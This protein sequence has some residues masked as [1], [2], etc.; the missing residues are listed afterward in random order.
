M[1]TKL[2][3]KNSRHL[4]AKEPSINKVSG[5]WPKPQLKLSTLVDTFQGFISIIRKPATKNIFLQL[6]LCKCLT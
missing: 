2:H 4:P 5:F 1:F 6:L 3:E